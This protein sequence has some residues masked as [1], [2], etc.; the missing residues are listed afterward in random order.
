MDRTSL[1]PYFVEVSLAACVAAFSFGAVARSVSAPPAEQVPAAVE[2]E[3]DEGEADVTPAQDGAEQR[4]AEAT[5]AP[6]RHEHQTVDFKTLRHDIEV[7]GSLLPDDEL[8]E[9]LLRFRRNVRPFETS[10][11]RLGVYIHNL[12]TGAVLTYN[13]DEPFYSASSIK[14]PYCLAVY[15]R[16]IDPGMV[17]A[18]DIASL[19]ELT[20]VESD[21]DTYQEM[22]ERCG[23]Q[24]FVD[25]A[26]DCG[27]LEKDSE[28]YHQL[29]VNR[30]WFVSS[31]QLGLMWE[32][33]YDYLQADSDGAQ[34]LKGYM[35]RRYDSP[36]RDGLPDGVTTYAKAGWYPEDLGP[37]YCA[38]VDAGIVSEGGFDYVIVVMTDMPAD[39]DR[40]SR[41]MPG[42]LSARTVTV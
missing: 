5:Q 15:E 39:L 8:R 23:R 22:S 20:L 42:V 9:Q 16:M 18:A 28:A 36:L 32:H 14:G 31:R 11:Q 13:A 3:T 37:E 27:A 33:G 1:P 24:V 25:W 21:N 10:G 2:T 40:L 7:S 34:E 26:V 17:P 30:H 19:T 38:T 35:E 12:T 4:A 6:E 41:L 29:I